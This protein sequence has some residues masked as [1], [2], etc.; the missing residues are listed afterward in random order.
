MHRPPGSMRPRKFLR[1]RVRLKGKSPGHAQYPATQARVSFA[2]SLRR[3]FP[4]GPWSTRMAILP[5]SRA[6][7]RLVICISRRE[8]RLVADDTQVWSM[9]SGKYYTLKR[10]SYYLDLDTCERTQHD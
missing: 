5:S 2:T 10:Y 3:L 1:N 7:N 8:R 9:I 6:P 4:R